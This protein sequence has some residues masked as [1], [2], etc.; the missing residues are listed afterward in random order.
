MYMYGVYM[1]MYMYMALECVY[2]K[3]YEAYYYRECYCSFVA[4]HY[5]IKITSDKFVI[6][7]H[8]HVF[9]G[10]ESDLRFYPSSLQFSPTDVYGVL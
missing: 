6:L 4:S 9:I 10:L 1:H 2:T 3:T 5:T 8:V 7:V